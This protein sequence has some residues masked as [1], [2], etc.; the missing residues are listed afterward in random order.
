[1]RQTIL[2]QVWVTTSGFFTPAPF[3]AALAVFG[4]DRIMFS[5]DYPFSSNRAATDFLAN[6]SAS[7][8]D[9]KK[10]AHGNA[11]ALLGLTA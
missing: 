4:A 10:I 5:V 9:K 1:M 2:D 8:E 3:A 11:D 7:A 6:L